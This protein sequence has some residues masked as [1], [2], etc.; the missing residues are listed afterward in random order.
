MLSQWGTTFLKS[1]S[2]KAFIIPDIRSVARVGVTKS[3]SK[4]FFVKSKNKREETEVER[5]IEIP[6]I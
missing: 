2:S 6:P 1:H 4:L 3:K 5:L